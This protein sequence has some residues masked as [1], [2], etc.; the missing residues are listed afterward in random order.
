MSNDKRLNS[1]LSN[2]IKEEV[3]YRYII[4]KKANFW[5]LLSKKIK[6]KLI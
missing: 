4:H 6:R 2:F 5:R 1:I 3:S